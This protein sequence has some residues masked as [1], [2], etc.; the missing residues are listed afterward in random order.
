[1]K[2]RSFKIA[3]AF[4][5]AVVGTMG[6]GPAALAATALPASRGGSIKNQVCGA[7]N[8]GVSTWVHFYYY[9]DDH[10]AECFA[11]KGFTTASANIASVCPGNNNGNAAIT[12][13]PY[14]IHFEAGSGRNGVYGSYDHITR[15]SITG[16]TGNAKCLG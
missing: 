2:K 6:L 14:N 16:W 3:T 9:H 4:A 8:G 1:M 7:N 13:Y 15:V 5:G 10:P 12:S 11:N